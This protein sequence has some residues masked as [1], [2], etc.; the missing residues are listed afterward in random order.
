MLAPSK[1]RHSEQLAAKLEEASSSVAWFEPDCYGCNKHAQGP[2]AVTSQSA[3]A[4]TVQLAMNPTDVLFEHELA[5]LTLPADPDRPPPSGGDLD[6]SLDALDGL[7]LAADLDEVTRL[8]ADTDVDVDSSSSSSSG[9]RRRPAPKCRLEQH[10]AAS[11]HRPHR[12]H[13]HAKKASR[14]QVHELQAM[15]NVM[16][17]QVD[18]AAAEI[19]HLTHLVGQF[20][21]QRQQERQQQERRRQGQQL[22]DEHEMDMDLDELQQQLHVQMELERLQFERHQQLQQQFQQNRTPRL[23]EPLRF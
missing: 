4:S 18:G 3:P 14:K 1:Q 10:G 2:P 15:V 12:P 6:A 22:L 19:Q 7:G 21:L 5:A 9:S 20:A 13:H 16:Q 8:C 11:P 17:A 23:P